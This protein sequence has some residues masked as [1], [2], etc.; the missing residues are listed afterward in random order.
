MLVFSYVGYKTLQ[1]NYAGNTMNVK[2][3]EESQQL[4]DV[5]VT[6]LGIKREEKGLGYATETVKGYDYECPAHQLVGGTERQGSRIE[7]YLFRWSA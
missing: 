1:K 3:A 5:V 6:A 4:N 7:C 2:L